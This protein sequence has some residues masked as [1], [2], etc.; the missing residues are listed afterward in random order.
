MEL[1]PSELRLSEFTGRKMIFVD[2]TDFRR[3]SSVLWNFG[4]K[5]P[6]GVKNFSLNSSK[7]SLRT[8]FQP[9]VPGCNPE[10][11]QDGPREQGSIFTEISC[12]VQNKDALLKELNAHIANLHTLYADLASGLPPKTDIKL[13]GPGVETP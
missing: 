3:K 8:N 10:P 1:T 4:L 13:V 9:L 12:S 11:C 6:V 7:W 2:P 5:A